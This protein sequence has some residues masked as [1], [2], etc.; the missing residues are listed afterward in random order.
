MSVHF[1]EQDKDAAIT[2]IKNLHWVR[3]YERNLSKVLYEE[4]LE[5]CF[6]KEGECRASIYKR[7]CSYDIFIY[8]KSSMI[9]SISINRESF[10]IRS[11]N[12][13]NVKSLIDFA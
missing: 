13:F 11:I 6:D 2:F 12:I 4:L 5:F 7:F 3:L 10:N 9:S 1:T 8:Y